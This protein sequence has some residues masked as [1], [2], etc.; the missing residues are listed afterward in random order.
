MQNIALSRV[1]QGSVLEP[2]FF[3]I[4]ISDISS[5]IKIDYSLYADRN[6]FFR[7]VCKILQSSLNMKFKAYISKEMTR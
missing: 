5:K 3:V 7:Q 6:D 1:P 2:L 4:Y